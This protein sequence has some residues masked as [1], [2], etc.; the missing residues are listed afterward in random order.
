MCGWARSPTRWPAQRLLASQNICFQACRVNG[1][2]CSDSHNIP[3]ASPSGPSMSR[4]RRSSGSKCATLTR[5]PPDR[6]PWHGR[7]GAQSIAAAPAT[8]GHTP[9]AP[10]RPWRWPVAARTA[11][12]HPSPGRAGSRK[13]SARSA[14]P[15]EAR[16]SALRAAHRPRKLLS[17]SPSEVYPRIP[18]SHQRRYAACVSHSTFSRPAPW[19]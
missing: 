14:R 2:P 11:D 19:L 6:P 13:P 10:S 5:A 18:T 8:P 7:S 1:A 17:S 15:I 16:C 4:L 9:T 3:G 12:S